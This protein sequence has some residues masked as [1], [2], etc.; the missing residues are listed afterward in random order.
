MPAISNDAWSWARSFAGTDWESGVCV[1]DAF[2]REQFTGLLDKNGKEI[3]EGDFLAYKK[4]RMEVFFD[5]LKG[6]YGVRFPNKWKVDTH[7]EFFK[8]LVW[9]AKRGELI[10]NIY[11]PTTPTERV[12]EEKE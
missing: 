1:G 6:R 4:E 3:Y 2:I 5:L 10:G 9:A 8:S 7:S 12:R 11:E